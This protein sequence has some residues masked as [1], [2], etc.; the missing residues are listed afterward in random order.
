[1]AIRIEVNGTN[2]ITGAGVRYRTPKIRRELGGTGKAT[3]TLQS[4]DGSWSPSLLDTLEVWEPVSRVTDGAMTNGDTTLTS[5]SSSFTAGNVGDHVSVAGAGTGGR[6]LKSTIVSVTDSTHVELEDQAE[7]TV[8][9]AT[10]LHGRCRFLGYLIDAPQGRIG[11]VP[12]T[13]EFA[14]Q[15][16]DLVGV[17]DRL[18]PRSSRPSETLIARLQALVSATGADD[19]GI[20]VY[21]P[22]LTVAK[23]F[24]DG[25]T[26]TFEDG[27]AYTFEA[28]QD[29]GATMAARDYD[30][31][32]SF[33]Q[34][35]HDLMTEDGSSRSWL[36]DTLGRLRASQPSVL[37]TPQALNEGDLHAAANPRVRFLLDDYCNRVV[38]HYGANLDAYVTEEDATELTAMNDRA[39]ERQVDDPTADVSSASTRAQTILAASATRDRYVFE[40][41]KTAVDGFEPGQFG[42]LTFTEYGV[43]GTHLI[44][45]VEAEYVELPGQPWHFSLIATNADVRATRWRDYLA[46]ISR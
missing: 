30:G 32:S 37:S 3:L 16:E 15:A 34:V 2:R 33:A 24:E 12:D 46:A 39:W 35:L 42:A 44:Q 27:S 8:S 25:S 13:L 38:Y 40:G 36:V 26:A 4:L 19:H 43:S 7:A 6:T 14:V 41:L 45:T 1:M 17:L 31:R 18:Y 21:A 5:A 23:L 10:V 20:S 22:E 11:R 29:V 28:S 9:N